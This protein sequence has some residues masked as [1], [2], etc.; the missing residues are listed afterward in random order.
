M[1]VTVAVS[2]VNAPRSI[3]LRNWGRNGPDRAVLGVRDPTEPPLKGQPPTAHQIQLAILG[4]VEEHIDIVER[5]SSC[6]GRPNSAWCPL[7]ESLVREHTLSV[8]A[9]RLARDPIAY[10]VGC[11][12]SCRLLVRMADLVGGGSGR[13]G[14][15]LGGGVMIAVTLGIERPRMMRRGTPTG[16]ELAAPKQHVPRARATYT[17]LTSVVIGVGRGVAAATASS[18]EV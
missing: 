7:V 10:G 12:G 14:G 17:R 4:G 9:H 1:P 6:A 8:S 13:A 18:V 11:S 2:T 16:R 5:H 15:I 3:N